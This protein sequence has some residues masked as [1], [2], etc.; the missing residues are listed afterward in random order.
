MSHIFML[1][2]LSLGMLAGWIWL[3]AAWKV[4]FGNLSDRMIENG[5]WVV[6]VNLFVLAVS[7]NL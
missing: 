1:L 3:Y 6:A 4:G 5:V 2:S 7:V